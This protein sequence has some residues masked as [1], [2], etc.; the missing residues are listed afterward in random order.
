[1]NKLQDPSQELSHQFYFFQI[2]FT[3]T[4]IICW[5]YY[6]YLLIRSSNGD[7]GVAFLNFG[8]VAIG[9]LLGFIL[10]ALFLGKLGYLKIFRLHNFLMLLVTLL[11][12]LTLPSIMS[13]YLALAV[14]RGF[15]Y[16]FFWM[17]NNVYTQREVFGLQRGRLISMLNGGGAVLAIVLPILAGAAIVS[18]GY[19][20]IFLISATVYFVGIIYP[21]KYNR[22]P[23]DVFRP[24]EIKNFSQKRGFK[25]WSIFTVCLEVLTDQRN[26]IM[27]IL[28]FVFIGNEFDIGILT[29]VL[30]LLAAMLVFVHRNDEIKRKVHLG[31]WGAAIVDSFTIGLSLIWNLPAL[32]IRSIAANFGFAY[33]SPVEGE[34]AYR[35]KEVMLGDFNQ[36]SANEMQV[37]VETL[38]TIA[39]IFNLVL[40]IVLLY[41]LK[42]NAVSL[43]QFLLFIGA[44]REIIYMVFSTN[45][46][47]NLKK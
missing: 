24:S 29:S 34:L 44:S 22:V 17:A 10:S 2:V 21:W 47:D 15:G 5:S 33:Y 46:L 42:L 35:L 11:T 12:F 1:M 43:M 8:L 7:Y 36:E 6:V 39:R 32:V 16:G 20:W 30:G 38:Y 41:V 19:T 37:Y 25:R 26:S 18:V 3:V 27:S 28:P 4:G 23:R 45:F 14:L 31:Y 13:V 9:Q 40:I